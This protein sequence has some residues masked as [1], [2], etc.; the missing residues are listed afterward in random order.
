MSGGQYALKDHARGFDA[1][2]V[3]HINTPGQLHRLGLPASVSEW[4]DTHALRALLAHGHDAMGNLLLGNVTRERFLNA[5]L[6]QPV[7]PADKPREYV[8]LAQT[9][10]RG[11]VAASSA[12]GEQPKFTV[13]GGA[14]WAWHRTTLTGSRGMSGSHLVLCHA[15]LRWNGIWQMPPGR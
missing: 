3:Y 9:A 2:P 12:G 10:M 13:F 4:S 5:P 6:L 7:S 11:D 14:C 15:W 1:L 8:H